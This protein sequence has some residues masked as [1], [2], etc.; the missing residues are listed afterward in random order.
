M[1]I[2]LTESLLGGFDI[3]STPPSSHRSF[4]TPSAGSMPDETTRTMPRR[5][6][7][8]GSFS[9]S[10]VQ[11]FR[12]I[13]KNTFDAEAAK[14]IA[15]QALDEEE[16][17]AK[18][19]GVSPTSSDHR[20]ATKDTKDWEKFNKTMLDMAVRSSK[21]L[22]VVFL[23]SLHAYLSAACTQPCRRFPR[24]PSGT[25][26]LSQVLFPGNSWSQ[27]SFLLFSL[28]APSTPSRLP[29]PHSSCLHRE[30]LAHHFSGAAG[31]ARGSR[32]EE[33]RKITE[34]K[35]VRCRFACYWCVAPA[36]EF[37]VLEMERDTFVVRVYVLTMSR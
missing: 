13:R 4:S 20:H 10:F 30:V 33:E 26:T 21:E 3:E 24:F 8:S 22:R 7:S 32:G 6:S 23:L 14:E 19:E 27:N 18:D 25:E 11:S 1:S 37:L 12:T 28:P 34:R 16:M 36:A 29:T 17:G 5:K 2:P 9:G 31:E 35:R 15:S